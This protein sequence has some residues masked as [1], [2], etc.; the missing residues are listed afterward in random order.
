MKICRNVFKILLTNNH[1]MI[2]LYK[3]KVFYIISQPS[4][5]QINKINLFLRHS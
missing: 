3:D 5:Y 1:V 2:A 4:K